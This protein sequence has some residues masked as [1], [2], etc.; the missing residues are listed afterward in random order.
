[1]QSRFLLLRILLALIACAAPFA[2]QA[3]SADQVRAMAIGESDTRSAAIA[4]A[5]ASGDPKAPE[6]FQALLD[7]AV[8]TAGERVFIVRDGKARD[9]ASGAEA[10]LPEGA[11]DVVNSNRMRRELESAVASLKLLS[12]DAAQRT[13]AVREMRDSA[14]ES[15]LPL[16]EKALAAETE[17]G[18]KADLQLLRAAVLISSSDKAKRL[19]AATALAASRSPATKTLLLDRLKPDAESDAEVRAQLQIA[20]SNIESRLAWGERLGVIFTGASLGSILL[21]VAL[22]LAITYGLMGVINMAH[23]ELMMI[24]AYATYVVQNLFKAYLPGLFDAYIVAAIPA[25]FLASALVGAA[26]ERSVIR[27]LYGRPL[28]TLLAT[29][30]ISLV[31]MQ[32]V[33][34]VFGAQNV[35]VENPSWL[36]G[37]VD[38]LSN[39]TL[40]F[41]RIAIIAFAVI[42]LGGLAFLV[43]RTRLGLFVRGVT[44]NRPMAACMGV[45]TA[46]VDTYAFALGS[47]IAGLAGCA[48]SQVGNVG[49]DLG[50]GYIV[51]SFMV[52]VLGGVGQLA[53]T[54]YAALGLGILNKLLEGWAGAVLAK[55][56]VL[57]VI[58]VFIQK[59]PQGLF[60][61]KGRS[62]EA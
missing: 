18:L 62:A 10:V 55:I 50:Q 3:L 9:A 37:G 32:A 15:R 38:V 26:M 35:Q 21:L 57:V 27:W 29:W 42:V 53:G 52:V 13:A 17:A 20:L 16:I 1:M 19:E 4:E 8:K 30:G 2:A 60:A 56:M 49:P 24:G 36:S 59:R 43:A 6:F 51:D 44:Q 61:M 25:S 14:D 5:A 7:D 22:G 12:P 28:E 11:E 46:R 31:L 45:N 41:N 48:L 47:G 33:R 34:S 23:G 58:V 39:L 40:P 54:V